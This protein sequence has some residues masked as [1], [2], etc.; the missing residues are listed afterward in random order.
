[1]L[2]AEDIYNE[3]VIKDLRLEIEEL[4]ARLSGS[5]D[6]LM[7]IQSEGVEGSVI[8]IPSVSQSFTPNNADYSYRVLIESMFDGAATL[9]QDLDITYS[10]GKLSEMLGLKLD[11]I[12]GKRVSSIIHPDDL[13]RFNSIIEKG[14]KETQNGEIRIMGNSGKEVPVL[15]SCTPLNNEGAVCLIFVEI[16]EIKKVQ[17]E[18]KTI[19]ENLDALVFK[20]TEE[21]RASEERL[22]ALVRATSDMVFR[23]SPDWSEIFN[24]SWDLTREETSNRNWLNDLIPEEEQPGLITSIQ[25]AIKNKSIYELE[26]RLNR[27]D[28]SQS[29]VL[30]RAIPILNNQGEIVEWFGTASDITGRKNAEEALRK[31]EQRWVTTLGS[32]G[33][34]VIAADIDGNITFMNPVAE[35]LTGWTI[36]EVRNKP[37][38]SAFNIIDEASRKYIQSPVHQ[39]LT[40]EKQITLSNHT[41][42]IKKDGTEI[43]VDDSA[44]PIF[45][46]KRQLTG[47][48]LVF[49]D[50]SERRK[51]ER[52]IIESEARLN[53]SQQIGHLGGWEFDVEN[54]ILT[55]SDE[56]YRIF[57]V[58]P[59][60]IEA[61]YDAFLETIH[62]EDRAKVDNAYIGSVKEGK[63][64]YEI[65]HRIIRKHTGEIRYVHEKCSHLRDN[66]GKIIK[67]VGMCHDITERKKVELSLYESE[68]RWITT[69]AS[70]GDAV[71]ATD[72]EGRIKFMNREAEKMT[73][74]S[75]YESLD[76][77]AQQ[78]LNILNE[79]TRQPIDYRDLAGNGSQGRNNPKILIN[80]DGGEIPIDDHVSPI[81]MKD[82]EILGIVLVFHDI[83][84]RRKTEEALRQ[85]EE[86]YRTIVETA[87]EGIW[88]LDADLNTSF[89]NQKMSEIL[90][91]R[92]DEMMG[93]SFYDFM[94]EEGKILMEERFNSR[95]KGMKGNYEHK[96]YNKDGT[97]VWVMVHATP[98]MDNNGIFAGTVG[99]FTDITDRKKAVELLYESEQRWATTLASIVDAVIA[100]DVSGMI[101]FMNSEAES[102]TGWN[103]AEALNQPVHMVLKVID[104]TTGQ[105]I[106]NM[107]EKV[108]TEGKVVGFSTNSILLSRNGK[109]TAIDH[110]G[111]T[112]KTEN[113]QITGVVLIFRDITERKSAEKVTK[114]YSK[115]LEEKVKK[116]TAQLEKAK[117]R[118]ES[119][120]KL[121]TAFLLNMSHELRTPLNSI[122]GF[123]GILIQQIPGPLNEEQI[124]QLKMVQTSGRHLLSLINDILDISRIDAGE[125][126]PHYE[127]FDI[128]EVIDEVLR[129]LQPFAS[130]KGLFINFIKT[131]GISQIECDRKRISQILI[132]LVNN[133][134]KFTEAGSVV[135][136]VRHDIDIVVIDV[137]DTGIGIK[138]EDKEKLFNPFLQLE[139]NLVRKFEGSGL[140]LS[141][142]KK[143]IDMLHG[144]ITVKSEYGKGSTFTIVLPVKKKW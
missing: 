6:T 54:N 62:P 117:E 108:I 37:A 97:P 128:H 106:E 26:H 95:R 92:Q 116:R 30:S 60:E 89:V 104:E 12:V 83:T 50:V 90:G 77:P 84:E 103:Q 140:G 118:A 101:T 137:S 20:R 88:T 136:Q 96:Y 102:L 107:V 115:H 17:E 47:M 68:Q 18:L 75:H 48:V 42:L 39:V 109:K 61:T 29:W 40:S 49:R 87:A 55:W 91:Y 98:L 133:A 67:S 25:K 22:R 35:K 124:K 99:M 73:R 138:E 142:S 59:R 86:K 51:A 78:I 14:K 110:S 76:K 27:P 114:N 57:G 24:L 23:L 129:L 13:A 32:I 69:L 7:S 111:A 100:T 45:N 144:S 112:I 63:D 33:D 70:I 8:N 105:E 79:Q 5:K 143:L 125:L 16:T 65:E 94:D 141:I 43:F 66:N 9:S 4:K 41:I 31:S 134:V 11:Q 135:I 123:S 126:K 80:K 52:E 81:R 130:S 74:W 58:E 44:S 122:I 10:N 64:G 131:P 38:E 139:N 36:E 119:A 93:R 71:I 85:S 34:A 3:S 1:M 72:N 28:G 2:S 121:K 127:I 56:I 132:N 53:R 21:L 113:C 19:N 46:E 15:L 120:D 82:G